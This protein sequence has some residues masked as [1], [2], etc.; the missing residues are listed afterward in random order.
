MSQIDSSAVPVLK[1]GANVHLI[2]INLIETEKN[3][4]R[5]IW[6]REEKYVRS[7]FLLVAIWITMTLYL[8]I[9]L[10]LY[11]LIIMLG[12]VTRIQWAGLAKDQFKVGDLP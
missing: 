7:L 9:I 4:R 10:I 5:I 6:W 1:A 2:E 12:T 8:L 11:S 3:M